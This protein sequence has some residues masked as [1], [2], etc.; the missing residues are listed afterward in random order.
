MG[1]C[2]QRDTGQGHPDK[3]TGQCAVDYLQIHGSLRWDGRIDNKIGAVFIRSVT[4]S[5]YIQSE[6][7]DIFGIK[8]NKNCNSLKDNF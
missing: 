7:S 8:S 5:K 4:Y 1:T 3:G 2:E 6:T